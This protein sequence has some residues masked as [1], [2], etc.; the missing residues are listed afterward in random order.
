MIAI[1]G[2]VFERKWEEIGELR[3]KMKCKIGL[4]KTTLTNIA[5]SLGWPADGLDS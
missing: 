5:A 3:K 4:I 1:D 2:E